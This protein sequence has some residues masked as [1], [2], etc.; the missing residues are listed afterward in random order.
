MNISLRGTP[1]VRP[2]ASTSQGN[3]TSGL[4]RVTTAAG[5]DHLAVTIGDGEAE[6]TIRT[7]SGSVT[8]R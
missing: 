2:D 5:D 1:N 7:S 4:L 3:V 6:L 8:I